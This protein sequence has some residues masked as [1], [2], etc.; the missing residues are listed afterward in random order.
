MLFVAHTGLLG[1]IQSRPY[2][3]FKLIK[4]GGMRDLYGK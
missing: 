4:T 3:V 2:Q 1:K